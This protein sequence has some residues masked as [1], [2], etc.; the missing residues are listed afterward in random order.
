MPTIK[1]SKKDVKINLGVSSV[2]PALEDLTVY[3]RSFEQKFNH[4]NSYGYDEITVEP[5]DIKLQNKEVKPSTS[6]QIITP[7]EEYD[8]LRELTVKAVDNTID[9]NIKSENIKSG[10]SILGVEGNIIELKG[11]ER[12]TTPTEETQVI[13]PSEG[14]NAI[15]QITVNPIPS[16][17]VV[18]EGTINITENGITNVKN[19]ETANVKIP[20]Y[21]TEP[22]I[23]DVNFIDYEGTLLYSYTLEEIQN[24]TELPELPS[25][26]G[27][28]CQGWNWTL[29]ELKELGRE[30]EVGAMYV[31]TDGK[32]KAHIHLYSPITGTIVYTQTVANSVVVDWGDG[33]P[34]ETSDIVGAVTLTHD[35]TSAG[36]YVIT[37]D[38]ESPYDL[39]NS[40][41]TSNNFN[42]MGSTA[43]NNKRWVTSLIK[44]YLGK[45]VRA[46]AYASFRE[47]NALKEISI[48]EGVSLLQGNVFYNANSL[49]GVVFPRS[50]YDFGGYMINQALG[51]RFLSIPPNF[52]QYAVSFLNDANTLKRFNM[53]NITGGLAAMNKIGINIEK[54][55]IPDSM[56]P[57]RYSS[58]GSRG[59]ANILY[60][61]ELRLP[62][63]WKTLTSAFV[64]NDHALEKLEFPST[65]N[66]I[67]SGAFN[68]T[69]G[70]KVIDFSKCTEVPI[71]QNKNAFTNC[72]AEIW[73]PANLYDEWITSTNWADVTNTFVAK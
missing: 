48:P 7:D 1:V 14:K 19:F 44:V 52:N 22:E 28:I 18:P 57:S 66:N 43:N 34:T 53:P 32:T 12:T 71:L 68:P 21:W 60:L 65:I 67:G 49:T 4:P 11:E 16:E 41:S 54:I 33:S 39:G 26:P 6:E 24:M 10:V 31:T 42:F 64:A 36:D 5:I 63:G 69:Y 15:T 20:N 50:S 70:L 17:Y 35:Y 61:K 62:E 72:P 8:G 9:E 23:K 38:S 37:L 47:A 73:I 45:N 51:M 40:V 30:M 25:H 55:Y 2:Y 29:E 3:P 58:G 59:F 46:L 13:T 56:D 27:L